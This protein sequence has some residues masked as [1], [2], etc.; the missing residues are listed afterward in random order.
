MQAKIVIFYA[1]SVYEIAMNIC[2]YYLCRWGRPYNNVSIACQ[3]V[4]EKNSIDKCR[5]E[6]E[7]LVQVLM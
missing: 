3:E 6:V 2:F 7:L 5:S 1:N 4:L